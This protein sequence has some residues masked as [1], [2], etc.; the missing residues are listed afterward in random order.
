M[1]RFTTRPFVWIG[2]IFLLLTPYTHAVAQETSPPAA[3]VKT[4]PPGT[5][6]KADTADKPV[7]KTPDK[8]S[9]KNDAASGDALKPAPKPA[10]KQSV[11]QVEVSAKRSD[12]T[13]ERRNSTAAKLVF[14]R[15][16]IEKYGDTNIGDVL[17]RLPSVTTSGGGI[18]LRGL[19]GYTQILINGDRIPPGFS[20]DQISPDQVDRIEIYRAPTAETGARAVAG[21]INIILKGPLRTGATDIRGG[22]RVFR[23]RLG[24]DLSVSRNDA[25]TDKI[26]YSYSL[27]GGY[28]ENRGSGENRNSDTLLSDASTVYNRVQHYESENRFKRLA[29]NA[30][31]EWK[32]GTGEQL[33]MQPFYYTYKSNNVSRAAI[34]QTA[35]SVLPPWVTRQGHGENHGDSVGMSL[36][37]SR[38]IDTDTR[39]EVRGNVNRYTGG[40]SSLTTYY[41]GG[42]LLQS[43]QDVTNSTIYRQSNLTAKL[44]RNLGDKH[45]LVAG[46]EAATTHSDDSTRTLFNG[47]VQ[48]PQFGDRQVADTRRTAWYLQDEWDPSP[49]WSAYAGVRGETI[50]TESDLAGY[51]VR[52]RSNV[53]TPLAHALWRFDAPKKDQIRMSLTQSYRSPNTYE[54]VARPSVNFAL[55]PPGANDALN[56]DYAGN[57]DLK[58]ERSNGIDLAFEHYL[59]SNGVVSVNLFSRRL[60]DLI[61]NTVALENVSWATS[62][63]Y[64]SRPRNLGTARHEGVEFDTKFQLKEFFDDAPPLNLRANVSF[65]RSHVDSV[66]GP[67][68]RMNGVPRVTGNAGADYRFSVVPL[69]VGGSVNFTP[70]YDTRLA[71]NQLVRATLARNIE[72]FALWTF[73]PKLKLRLSVNNLLPRD[74]PS[75]SVFDTEGHRLTSYSQNPG[76]MSGGLRLE[77]RL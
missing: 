70:G 58:P 25:F 44:I 31:V 6:P 47:V 74:T 11:E 48:L 65:F 67:D 21:T 45:K 8:P 35:G 57:P 76:R 12:E 68:N 77:M 20:L 38:R 27:N 26:S 62:P 43:V 16:D 14:G 69:T 37:L 72:A 10:P 39:Y 54:L 24:E 66:P 3:P 32:F 51:A 64:V 30:Q 53:V 61:R 73:N 17:K 49:K 23:G 13:E 59:K 4:P 29:A 42:Q 33:V 5:E 46:L 1:T 60:R 71:D 50:T 52:N 22:T 75:T 28:T 55:A 2:A 34:E 63:R 36:N 18:G 40:N 15:E 19:P 56:A 7:V 41:A 9:A